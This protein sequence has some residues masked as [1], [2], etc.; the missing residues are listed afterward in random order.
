MSEIKLIVG[1]SNS[2]KDYIAENRYSNFKLLK[3]NQAFK[4]I[5]EIDHSLLPNTCNV[6]SHR[7]DVLQSGPLKGMTIQ[8]GMVL[9]Y[10]QSQAR[11]GYGVKFT[12]MTILSVL[13]EISE[14]S[15]NRTPVVITDVR[16]TTELKILANFAEV[17]D[18]DISMISVISNKAT[19]ATSDQSLP[20]NIYLFEQLTGKSAQKCYNN[21]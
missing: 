7:N 6:K 11:L 3:C 17:I 20:D 21:Y 2:G 8:E 16:K 18:Y 13:N 4:T 12:T 10:H 5:F 15:L 9:A 14:C 1:L 19:L